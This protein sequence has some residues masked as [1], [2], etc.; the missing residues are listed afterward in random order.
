MLRK[1]VKSL[2][3][4]L[5]V[6]IFSE[7]VFG[8][9]CTLSYQQVMDILTRLTEARLPFRWSMLNGKSRSHSPSLILLP[10]L[11]ARSQG[12]KKSIKRGKTKAQTPAVI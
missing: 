7:I 12:R 8:V 5:Q 4:Q 6:C 2:L 3:E 1:N 11:F 10:H 9:R